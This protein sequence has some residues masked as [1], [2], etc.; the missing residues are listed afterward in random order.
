MTSTSDIFT[1]TK[2]IVTAINS[3]ATSLAENFSNSTALGV[4]EIKLVMTGATRL[5]SFTVIQAGG[6]P[7]YIYDASSIET[8]QGYTILSALANGMNIIINFSTGYTFPVGSTVFLKNTSTT[9]DGAYVVRTSGP[10][11]LTALTS[12]TGNASSGTI[13]SG[14]IIVVMPNTVGIYLINWPVLFGIVIQPGTGQ[15]VS[16]SWQ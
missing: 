15:I 14:S 12:Q 13:G 4:A 9:L 7:G 2:N 1:T 3:A 10:G 6:D 5:I 16:A 8:V 11:T